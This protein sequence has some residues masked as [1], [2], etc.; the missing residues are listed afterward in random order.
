MVKNTR[1]GFVWCATLEIYVTH[2]IR[3]GHTTYQC[4]NGSL[5]V[6][7]YAYLFTPDAGLEQN[8]SFLILRQKLGSI[9]LKFLLN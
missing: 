8:F 3:L 4:T 9:F 2:V 7:S 1:E 5:S 6:S